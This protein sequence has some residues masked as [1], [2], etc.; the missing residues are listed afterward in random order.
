MIEVGKNWEGL[1]AQ[2]AAAAILHTFGQ[3][4]NGHLHSHDMV[5]AGGLSPDGKRW[6]SLPSSE[7]LPY[8][9]LRNAYRD[10]FLKMLEKAYRKRKLVFRDTLWYLDDPDA[11]EQWRDKM[12]RQ[13]W[14][15]RMRSVSG[16]DRETG[17]G[18]FG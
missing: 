3:R 15:I 4:M 1:Q 7:F 16:H 6:I 18:P 8:E 12:R 11:F 17:G 5:P 14:V 10:L 9:Q 2:M 13:E